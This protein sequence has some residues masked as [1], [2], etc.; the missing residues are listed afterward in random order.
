ME[1]DRAAGSGGN[2][3]PNWRELF[4]EP[5]RSSWIVDL[6]PAQQT[7]VAPRRI[8]L[9]SD[10]YVSV[11][12]EAYHFPFRRRLTTTYTPVVAFE[13]SWKMPTSDDETSLSITG[14]GDTPLAGAG[15]GGSFAS[16]RKV[17]FGPVCLNGVFKLRAGLYV[18]KWNEKTR[19]AI[20]LVK[21]GADIA[22]GADVMMLK[23]VSKAAFALLK[24]L[25]PD[26][27]SP[28]YA[29][30]D[31]EL[32][33]G[34][35]AELSTGTWAVLPEQ[36]ERRQITFNPMERRLETLNGKALKCP[37]FVYS[38]I[39]HERHP[40]RLKLPEIHEARMRLQRAVKGNPTITPE[41]L[42]E[43]HKGYLLSIKFC[44]RLNRK[45][46]N[47]LSAE[48]DEMYTDVLSIIGAAGGRIEGAALEKLTDRVEESRIPKASFSR[49][50]GGLA[51]DEIADAAY[52]DA[53]AAVEA[54][55][56]D[57][58]GATDIEDA[59][60][61]LRAALADIARLVIEDEETWS[62]KAIQ[63]ADHL[64]RRRQ[65]SAL[66]DFVIQIR[67]GGAHV[68]WLYY[69]GAFAAVEMGELEPAE[70]QLNWLL[71]RARTDLQAEPASRSRALLLSDALGLR[72]RIWKSRAA[73][74]EPGDPELHHAY[75]QALNLYSEAEHLT[76]EHSVFNAGD[77]DYHRVNILA[78]I[79]SAEKKGLKE[80]GRRKRAYRASRDWA[81]E[82]LGRLQS[83]NETPKDYELANGGDAAMFL[84]DEALAAE[85]YGRYVETQR[86]EPFRM[87]NC[88]RQM[89]ELW[90]VD[91][92][93]RG[94]L[95]ALVQEM[96]LLA[97]TGPQS[98]SFTTEEAE[99][100]LAAA[101]A[102]EDTLQAS[103]DGVSGTLIEEIADVIELSRSVGLV[104][105]ADGTEVGTGF[106]MEGGQIHPDLAGEYVFLT[107]DHV[108]SDHRTYAGTVSS[109][110][111]RIF[112]ERT[113]QRF[114]CTVK[115]VFWRSPVLKHDCAILRLNDLPPV[116]RPIEVSP[117]LPRRWLN[118]GGYDPQAAE[119]SASRVYVIGHPLGGAMRITLEKHFFIDHDGPDSAAQASAEPVNV[120]YRAPTEKGNSGSPVFDAQSRMLI[121]IHHKA[122]RTPLNGRRPAR[123][124]P[125]QANQGKWIC[126]IIQ[127]V[128][129]EKPVSG[130]GGPDAVMP[131]TDEPD[132]GAPAAGAIASHGE[133]RPGA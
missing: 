109:G 101:Q 83:M 68:P 113:N 66:Y 90:G 71:P 59:E 128:R 120:H 41:E 30:I 87:N 124:A 17:M 6:S 70:A 103:F 86:A 28:C 78:L 35:G 106:L 22:S 110:E 105:R 92:A 33:E 34:A 21:L 13:T 47:E 19:E 9:N 94:R 89:V 24:K 8:E 42:S 44:D 115:E 123:G 129:A 18:S 20:D 53:V 15:R 64:R 2:G 133:S 104:K 84:G 56:A 49:E 82:I 108:V 74:L 50:R 26:K 125:Y 5:G 7:E 132:S 80:F 97:A 48:A 51:Q 57:G 31:I 121:A 73:G 3:A 11:I 100:I 118:S 1:R 39:A 55:T 4:I 52:K 46:K 43:L 62:E 36:F 112:F 126:S 60:A 95:P 102:G 107:N 98:V 65:F 96:G 63:M 58:A 76:F 99:A 54:G 91:P 81:Q 38:I 72:G 93:G 114:P 27:P 69:Y 14:P 32:P 88:R 61:R 25:F 131:E 85:Y 37:Y 127:A 16:G 45:D 12:L 23:P 130:R 75:S 111:A 10:Y 29:G 77:T 116:S 117:V 67:D 122:S 40:E 119:R 79:H